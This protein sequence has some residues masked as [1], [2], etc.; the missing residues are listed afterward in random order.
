MFISSEIFCR[1][2]ALVKGIDVVIK[3]VP[4]LDVRGL[5]EESLAKP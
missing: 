3:A 1:E 5:C 2:Y 4:P